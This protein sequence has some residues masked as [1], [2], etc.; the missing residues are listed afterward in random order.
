MSTNFKRYVKSDYQEFANALRECLG[1]CP[2]YG[3]DE[4]SE[5]RQE[6]S[7]PGIESIPIEKYDGIPREGAG[8]LERHIDEELTLR[9]KK[10]K[11]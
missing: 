6:H 4:P 1:L 8:S 10:G 2:L 7:W 9:T 3:A 11:A 5:Y